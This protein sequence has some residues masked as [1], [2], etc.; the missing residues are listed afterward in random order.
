[1]TSD[2]VPPDE[3]TEFAAAADLIESEYP[4]AASALRAVAVPRQEKPRALRRRMLRRIW[5]DQH[6]DLSRTAA[7]RVIAVEWKS[8][9]PYQGDEL[10]GTA[11][12][13]FARLRDAEIRPIAWRQ[14]ADDLDAELS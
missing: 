8:W 7:A 9:I 14:I 13:A 6:W 2:A 12:E 1:M 3:A 5:R 10:P 11:A 4:R